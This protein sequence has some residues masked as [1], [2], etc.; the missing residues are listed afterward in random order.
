M[1]GCR[2][3]RLKFPSRK[4]RS[5]VHYEGLLDFMFCASLKNPNKVFVTGFPVAVLDVKDSLRIWA[6]QSISSQ[7]EFVI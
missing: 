6:L 5:N 2:R 7:K 4:P 3:F 1:I